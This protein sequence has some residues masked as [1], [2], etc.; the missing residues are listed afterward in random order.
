MKRFLFSAAV[1]CATLGFTSCDPDKGKI[2]DDFTINAT[3][4][5]GSDANQVDEVRAMSYIYGEDIPVDYDNDGEIDWYENGEG[6]DIIIATAPFTNGGFKM[7]LPKTIDERLLSSM[8]DVP[9]GITVSN[10]NL[11]AASIEEFVAFKNDLRVGEF[12][13]VGF[14]FQGEVESRLNY[15]FAD[16]D[17]KISGSS[18]ETYWEYTYIDNYDIDLKKGWNIIYMTQ[19]EE[20][21]T[22]TFNLTTQKP[23]F[24]YVWYF[25]DGYYGDYDKPQKN[26]KKT[27]KKVFKFLK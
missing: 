20:D 18:T 4:A 26:A 21:N 3:V 17:C 11:K 8:S 22:Y 15:T 9:P 12:W 7:T 1:L 24:N 2:T 25:E 27:P 19:I 5:N 10:Q 23:S 14:G 16:R 13:C 6:E